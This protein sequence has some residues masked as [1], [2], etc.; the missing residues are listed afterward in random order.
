MSCWPP[1]EDGDPGSCSLTVLAVGVG[2]LDQFVGGCMLQMLLDP[3]NLSP[4]FVLPR[5]ALAL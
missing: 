2:E 3:F 1:V 5:S 4:V